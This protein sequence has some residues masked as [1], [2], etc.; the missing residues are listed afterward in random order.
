MT[1]S[2]AISFFQP[3]ERSS[4]RQFVLFVALPLLFAACIY[5][6]FRSKYIWLNQWL[7]LA[8]RELGFSSNLL[9]IRALIGS[10]CLPNWLTYHLPDALWLFAST[11]SMQLLWRGEKTYYMLR[12]LPLWMAIGHEFAQLL[13]YISGTFDWK[14][15]LAYLIA[16]FVAIALYLM[17]NSFNPFYL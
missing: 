13:G 8:A 6:F 4:A 10:Y 9:Q 5:V 14:D 2:K 11:Y 17:L 1:F 12:I 7:I 16:Y 3:A 15:L